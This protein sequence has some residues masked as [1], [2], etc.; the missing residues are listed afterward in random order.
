MSQLEFCSSESEL[1]ICPS[2]L[3]GFQCF[4]SEF[5]ASPP[6][7]L[8]SQKPWRGMHSSYQSCLHPISNS[9]TSPVDFFSLVFLESSFFCPIAL[10]S[11]QFSG[12]PLGAISSPG[13]HLGISGDSFGCHNLEIATDIQWV[14]TR[15][16][17]KH[18]TMHRKAPQTI[19][20][21]QM[22]VIFRLR[23]PTLVKPAPSHS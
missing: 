13:G 16:A 4:L 2:S 20:Q 18:S 5:M 15:G 3:I 7:E 21:P 14:E 9:S 12:S 10:R 8:H 17:V 19:I 6:V 22:S 23:T 1:V 11:F